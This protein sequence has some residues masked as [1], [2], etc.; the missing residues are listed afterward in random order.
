M[1]SRKLIVRQTGSQAIPFYDVKD[2]QVLRFYYE[3]LS[4]G[5][6]PFI[7]KW[8][9]EANVPGSNILHR[10]RL[11][12]QV[13]VDSLSSIPCRCLSQKPHLNRLAF[14]HQEISCHVECFAVF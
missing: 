5:M 1:I 12:G 13:L 6:A 14:G 2:S 11:N 3:F 8:V 9:L 10:N 4:A 7:L